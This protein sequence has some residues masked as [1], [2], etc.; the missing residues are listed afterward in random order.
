MD[1]FP[2]DQYGQQQ[3]SK[4]HNPQ[5][6]K[7]KLKFSNRRSQQKAKLK[8]IHTYAKRPKSSI[9]AT[10]FRSSRLEN[11]P[12]RTIFCPYLFYMPSTH[13][14]ILSVKI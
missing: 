13:L 12:Y 9:T 11:K 10:Y 6:W 8:K 4:I 2:K 3:S 1:M 14:L 7:C 5:R